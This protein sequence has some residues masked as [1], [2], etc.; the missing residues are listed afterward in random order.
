MP[1]FPLGSVLLPRMPLS[2]RLFEPRYLLM[3][4]HVLAQ[5]VPEFGVVLI[6]RGREVG[7]GD[8]RFR[9]GTVARIAQVAMGDDAV[10]LTAIG[11]RRIVID[12]WLDDDPWP[13][14]E[15]SELPELSVVGSGEA[16]A[17]TGLRVRRSLARAAEFGE[18]DWPADVEL[19][20]DPEI[21]AWQLAGVAPIS[22]IDRYE[23]LAAATLADLLEGL[24]R[25][26]EHADAVR[27]APAPGGA[28][29][30]E[31]AELLGD[32]VG[33]DEGDAGDA[34]GEPDDDPDADPDP[35]GAPRAG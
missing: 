13:R 24:D 32:A 1:M 27:E 16:L 9:T 25:A 33:E 5:D 20:E 14:A 26:L 30:A 29:E 2:L 34:D 17:S 6:E 21:A 10:A 12:R 28:L 4:Q 18:A 8:S 3:L 11:T 23:L 19:S 35:G 22:T 15:V 7:G 31:L